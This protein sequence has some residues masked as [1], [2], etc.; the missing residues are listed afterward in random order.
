[1]AIGDRTSRVTLIA[2][3]KAD[4]AEMERAYKRLAK[5]SGERAESTDKDNKKVD[6][7]IG[8]Q[9]DSLRKQVGAV[10]G[11]ASAYKA[12]QFAME[13]F[14]FSLERGRLEAGAQ[15]VDIEKLRAASKGLRSETDLLRDAVKFQSGAFKLSQ[16]DM[17]SAEKAM[18]SLTRKG[19][20]Q[21]KAS[22]EIKK[23]LTELNVDGLKP[24]GIFVDKAG[25]SMDDAA[26]RAELYKRVLGA[27]NDEAKNVG[28]A[29][30]TK[31]E[32]TAASGVAFTDAVDRIKI[33]LGKMVEALT[34]VI[35]K[36]TWLLEKVPGAGSRT[37]SF[38]GEFVKEQ[39]G[40]KDLYLT[41]LEGV[42]SPGEI[43]AARA[44]RAARVYELLKLG[45]NVKALN[46]GQGRAEEESLDIGGKLLELLG[47]SLRELQGASVSP[48]GPYK[49]KAARD[50]DVAEAQRIAA[51]AQRIAADFDKRQ[52]QIVAE[53]L[54]EDT[55]KLG[56]DIQDKIN[57]ALEALKGFGE[58]IEKVKELK[59]SDNRSFMEKMLGPLDQF[60]LYTKAFEGF[61]SI[62]TSAFDAWITGAESMG[63]AAK[64][65]TGSVL[66]SIALEML[67]EAIKFGAKSLGAFAMGDVVHGPMYAATSA[68]YFAGAAAVGVLAKSIGGGGTT[69]AAGAGVGAAAPA[70]RGGGGSN[71]PQYQ[72]TQQV[73]VI[74]DSFGETTARGRIASTKRRLA[75]AGIATSGVVDS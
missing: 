22:G 73:I 25:L 35:E 65:A 40:L 52:T 53:S 17:E 32:R 55:A 36:V 31:A 37:I 69:G 12:G 28:D 66:K 50:R 62:S 75:Q 34:P 74:G 4:T 43:V 11:L 60:D 38:L 58:N 1:M 2:V 9:I 7:S 21:A 51:E 26:D 39:Y 42:Q 18:L 61:L 23:A 47:P 8:D 5:A 6:K 44:Q 71:A 45:E 14:G 54:G 56:G 33:A 19:H 49:G 46:L 68:K 29:E 10:I 16:G 70:G 24:L 3:Y 15:G 64:R 13:A 59:T 72:G 27:V 20:D 67:G 30:L 41:G 63:E 48:K 57:T